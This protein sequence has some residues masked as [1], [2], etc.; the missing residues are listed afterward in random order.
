MATSGVIQNE[1]SAEYIIEKAFRKMRV[2]AAEQPLTGTQ[3]Q[4]GLDALNDML[5]TQDFNGEHLWK[6]GRGVLFLD[7]GKNSYSLGPN[8]D[9]ATTSDDFQYLTVSTAA[10]VSDSKIYTSATTGVLVGD[11]VGIELD[12]GT[13]QWTTITDFS[14]TWIQLS[15][16]V[17]DTVAVGKSVYLYTNKI[18]R[19][20]RVLRNES[21]IQQY[22]DVINSETMLNVITREKYTRKPAKLTQGRPTSIYHEPTKNNSKMFVWP[23]PDKVNDVVRFN[24][25]TSMEIITDKTQNM[26]IPD[27]WQEVFIYGLAARLVDD[28]PVSGEQSTLIL[29]KA[30]QLFDK[31]IGAD[32]QLKSHSPR[33]KRY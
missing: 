2:K 16:G 32:Q 5:K 30:R 33:L 6:I 17:T 13:R 20:T 14:T 31:A 28:Y 22:N 4:D 25:K 7:K 10:V 1:R 8:G 15:I 27:S 21:S 11:N 26:D 29:T 3:M 9:H 18:D 12:D 19:P 24:Y 23:A